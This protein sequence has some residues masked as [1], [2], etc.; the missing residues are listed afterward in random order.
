M[1]F[2]SIRRKQILILFLGILS[3]LFFTKATHAQKF[4]VSVFG[5]LNHLFEYGSED[6]YVLGENDFPVTPSHTSANFGVAFAYFFTD[7]LGLE[8]DGRYTLSSKVTLL[9]PSDQDTVEIDTA[10]HYALTLN[11]IY[12]FLS[13]SFRPYIVAGG[14]IDKLLTKEETYTSEYGYEIVLEAPE[15]TVDLVVNVGA[16]IQYFIKP[17]LGAKFDFR[18]VL[19]FDDPNNLSS[20]NFAF[21]AFFIF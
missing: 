15:K 9:D 7:N 6:D 4:Q 11:F 12:R 21:G 16:G 5:G 10:K 17:N 1:K 19:I 2:R 14:G 13:D 20:L 18:Y 3:F 8:L